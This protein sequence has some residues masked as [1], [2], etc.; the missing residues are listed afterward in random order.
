[1]ST[2]GPYR[3]GEVI[4]FTITVYNQGSILAEDIEITDYIPCGYR[5]LSVNDTNGWSYD[6]GTGNATM[7][8]ANSLS[9]GSNVMLQRSVEQ[10]VAIQTNHQRI[11]IVTQIVIQTMMVIRS[12]MK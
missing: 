10:I 12:M 6:S 1:V 4:D 9:P 5:Y 7:T 2:A 11:S 8:L 3:Y